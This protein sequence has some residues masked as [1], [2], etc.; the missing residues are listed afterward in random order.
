[1][2]STVR[3]DATL[4][5]ELKSIGWE[6]ALQLVSV[7]K[8]R[9]DGTTGPAPPAGRGNVLT[10]HVVDDGYLNGT[11]YAIQPRAAGYADDRAVWNAV[12]DHPGYAVVDTT[13]LDAQGTTPAVVGGIS[14]NDST[15]K[16][17]QLELAGFQE[18]GGTTSKKSRVTVIGFMTRPI[19]GGLYV[20]T[21]TA[22]NSGAFTAAPAASA[23]QPLTPT[24]YYFSVRPGVDVNKTRLDLGRLLV[25]DQLEPVSV[26]DQVAQGN[27][28]IVTLLNLLTGFLALGLV[29]GVA[30][31]G[32]ISTRA[33]V[34]RRQQIGMM[35]ALGFRRSHVQRAFLM[36][37][38]FIAILGL[39]LGS[40]VGLWQSYRFFVTEKALGTVVFHVPVVEL[41]L[42]LL[43]SYIATLLTTYLPARAASRVAPAEALRYE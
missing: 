17:F 25:K 40:L 24:G 9:A 1:V 42:I 11:G 39:A 13:M 30:G 10:L 6:N 32:V 23:A 14:P 37:S 20:S 28:A 2:A 8:V 43:G 34:E 35:R 31:L 15:F 26:A 22:L 27:S 12:R 19:W 3:A 16:P 18:K 21:R 41:S 29:V 7:R 5:R 36:E 4:N 33:V 38:S